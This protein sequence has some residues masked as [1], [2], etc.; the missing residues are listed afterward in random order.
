MPVYNTEAAYLRSA[1]DSV[2]KQ[3]Y[4]N[5][6]IIIV[7]DGSKTPCAQECDALGAL[8][9]RITVI[10]QP[11]GGVSSARNCGADH[12]D[13]SYIMYMDSDDLLAP[14]ALQEAV[15]VIS[16][17]N[18]QMLFA[19][20]QKI[21]RYDAFCGTDGSAAPDYH[22]YEKD[23]IE[24]L[25]KSFFT[26]RNPEFNDIQGKG[27]VNRGPCARLIRTDIAKATRF[28]NRLVIGE[29]VEWNMRLLNA[30]DVV[31]FVNSIW[32]GYLIYNTSSLRK[33]YG[34]RVDL[35]EDY[36][37]LMYSRNKVF[38]DKYPAVFATNMVVSF[39][40]MAIFEYLSKECPLSASQKRKE[41]KKFLAREPWTIFKRKEVFNK[42]PKRYRYFLIACHLGLG[43]E[44]LAIWEG[45]KRAKINR[46]DKKQTNEG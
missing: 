3:T 36:H 25:M 5:I 16:H 41:L 2:L 6:E 33:Y 32:Y 21:R 35:L 1:V 22:K 46:A 40:S 10:H 43:L 31:C 15:E 9:P 38:C 29:D 13:G 11:N 37:N 39:Y 23:E 19:G 30:C 4:T 34:N 24:F 45:L 7:D 27:F 44:L 28:E 14:A 12:A 20:I 42:I 26:Q 17:T 8:D 18:A